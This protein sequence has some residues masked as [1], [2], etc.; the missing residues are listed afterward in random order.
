MLRNTMCLR[1]FGNAKTALDLRVQEAEILK[2]SGRPRVNESPQSIAYL[3]K[4]VDYVKADSLALKRQR[5]ML[6]NEWRTLPVLRNI[7]EEGY[8][9]YATK[10][11]D[12]RLAQQCRDRVVARRR[13]KQLRAEREIRE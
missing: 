13:V 4:K 10:M 9:L 6:Y 1:I 11:V 12:E 5:I 8:P 2:T 3:R 7:V